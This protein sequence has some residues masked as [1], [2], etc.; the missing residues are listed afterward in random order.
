MSSHLDIWL[1]KTITSS[2]Q[3]Y[4][5]WTEICNDFCEYIFLN[6]TVTRNIGPLRSGDTFY[7]IDSDVVA[8]GKVQL[9]AYVNSTDPCFLRLA[10]ET[11]IDQIVIDLSKE[12][13]LHLF[14]VV[15]NQKL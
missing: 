9:F 15:G 14:G 6:V 13:P 7:S 3:P 11:S 2:L 10:N 4:F 1:C 12:L 5:T 8:G